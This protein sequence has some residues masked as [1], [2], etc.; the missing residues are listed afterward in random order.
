MRGQSGLPAN[1]LMA[2][3]RAFGHH[4]LECLCRTFLRRA[5]NYDQ[6]IQT[7]AELEENQM[8]KYR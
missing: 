5:G 3:I 1:R 4:G 6:F 2:T 8:K 7:R